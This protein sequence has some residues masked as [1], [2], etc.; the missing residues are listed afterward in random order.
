MPTGLLVPILVQVLLGV[1]D[2]EIVQQLSDEDRARLEQAYGRAE[3]AVTYAR[4]I[5]QTAGVPQLSMADISGDMPVAAGH[6]G[7]LSFGQTP[8]GAPYNLS[9]TIQGGPGNWSLAVPDFSGP[10]PLQQRET[11][12][13]FITDPQW[14]EVAVSTSPSEGQAFASIF[15]RLRGLVPQP[16]SAFEAANIPMEDPFADL[17]GIIERMGEY[18]GGFLRRGDLGRVT[19]A[20]L[21]PERLTDPEAWRASAESEMYGRE[22]EQLQTERVQSRRALTEAGV[23]PSSAT[24]GYETEAGPRQQSAERTAQALTEI[25]A[26]TETIAGRNAEIEAQARMAA[27]QINAQL[28]GTETSQINQQMAIL[29]QLSQGAEGLNLQAQ[30]GRLDAARQDSANQFQTFAGQYQVEQ[31]AL[32]QFNQMITL[33][34]NLSTFGANVAT[35]I[36]MAVIQAELADKP[37]A[38]LSSDIM[39]NAVNLGLSFA[40]GLQVLNPQEDENQT[41]FGFAPMGVFGPSGG[42]SF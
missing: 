23:L 9:G 10:I 2:R 40:Q 34:A 28:A 11:G 12:E 3:D 27:E 31:G 25:G 7:S 39:T 13:L 22:G 1:S 26:E 38:I 30:A 42:V 4:N 36:A 29:S 19:A 32:D 18:G 5:A 33:N 6:Q 17:E 14:G 37:D 20:E 35:Q 24:F 16:P 8:G 21:M 41:S 15:D